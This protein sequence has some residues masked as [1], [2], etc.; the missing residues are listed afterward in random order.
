[1]NSHEYNDLHC[2]HLLP[3][4][5]KVKKKDSDLACPAAVRLSDGVVQ[6]ALLA[7]RGA[8]F[9]IYIDGLVELNIL[10][11]VVEIILVLVWHFFVDE[12]IFFF[13]CLIQA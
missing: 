3:K 7:C 12:F 8:V 2:R 4:N 11:L 6:E 9:V 13:I 5:K 1:M 10:A